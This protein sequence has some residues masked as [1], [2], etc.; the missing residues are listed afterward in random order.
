MTMGISLF[1]VGGISAFVYASV[2][3]FLYVYLWTRWS[4]INGSEADKI[5]TTIHQK[6]GEWSALWWGI[7]IIPYAMIPVFLAVLKA[8]WKDDASLASMGFIAGMIALILGIIG[9]L[10]SATTTDTLSRIHATGNEVEKTAAQV[11][12]KSGESYGKGLFCLFGAT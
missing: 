11:I 5:L 4:I 1:T 9:P 6:H 7:T 3:L 12:Y 10:G 8:L 2:T